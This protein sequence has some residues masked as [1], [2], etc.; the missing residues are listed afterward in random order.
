MTTNSRECHD[1]AP[2]RGFTYAPLLEPAK[3]LRLLS[4]ETSCSATHLSCRLETFDREAC[5]VYYALSYVYG[6]SSMREP[7]L[8]NGEEADLNRNGWRVLQQ[9]RAQAHVGSYYWID[10]LC[11][12]QT[13]LE[14]KAVQ[15]QKIADIFTGAAEVWTCFGAHEDDSKIL[16][17]A[18]A[19]FPLQDPSS[20]VD[21]SL[22]ERSDDMQRRTVNWLVSLGD[23]FERFATA[24]KAFGRRPFFSRT[25]IY[26]ELYLAS[27]V[28]M[29]CGNESANMEALKEISLIC[30]TL[31]IS[32]RPQWDYDYKQ[33]Q[34]ELMD[35]LA[36]ADL[37]VKLPDPD[38]HDL[39]IMTHQIHRKA[40]RA[41][42]LHY[43]GPYGIV[44]I[45]NAI[46]NLRCQNPRDKI[47]A[48]LSL[49]GRSSGILPDYGISCFELA[50][51]VLREHSR[52]EGQQMPFQLAALLC[53]NLRLDT[54]A[55]DVRNATIRNNALEIDDV[56]LSGWIN[57]ATML[58]NRSTFACQVRRTSSGHMT[59]PFLTE[60]DPNLDQHWN[61]VKK[62][63]PSNMEREPFLSNDNRC[64]F[65]DQRHVAIATCNLS[66]GD[67]IVPLSDYD[68]EMSLETYCYGLI[69]RSNGLDSYRIAGELA[70]FPYC[71]PCCSWDRCGCGSGPQSHPDFHTSFDFSIDREELLLLSI[72][73]RAPF[74]TMRQESHYRACRPPL[75]PT[76]PPMKWHFTSA[77]RNNSTT[78][79][80]G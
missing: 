23:E 30:S 13:D 70:F 14:E 78:P 64:V 1:E 47:F 32:Y 15:V 58:R 52:W 24:L 50:L 44:R 28:I 41:E 40:E 31:L 72:R 63:L 45:Q 79:L 33:V 38:L 49:L 59:A 22:D 53:V 76:G 74:E 71:R 68:S 10:A 69:L 77:T 27:K 51:Q 4:F 21:T 39:N 20:Q 65:A 35:M 7:I 56:R 34:L 11:I 8:V 2:H 48:T 60:S 75:L 29:I 9:A 42:A 57:S 19:S 37:F 55:A 16:F 25:W 73:L 62:P 5:P 61:G 12:N 3:Q 66:D 67:W 80:T 6:D 46:K 17:R 18:L 36:K 26:Q 54:S 43:S